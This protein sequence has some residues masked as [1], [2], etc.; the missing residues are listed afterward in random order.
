[1]NKLRKHN[2]KYINKIE[3]KLKETVNKNLF[4]QIDLLYSKNKM[5]SLF[6][7]VSSKL[8]KNL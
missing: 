8:W 6:F 4:K 2:T 5:G 1:M 3:T 7:Q